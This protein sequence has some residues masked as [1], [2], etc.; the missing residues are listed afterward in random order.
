MQNKEIYNQF[1]ALSTKKD[2]GKDYEVIPINNS[3]H[4]IGCSKEG[5]PK[6]FIATS[7][8]SN[9]T[10]NT[11]LNILFVE[12]NLLCKHIDD[13]NK[14]VSQYYTVITLT[15]I[16]TCLQEDFIDLVVMMLTRLP[17]VPTKKEISIE[18]ENLISIFSSMSC[19]PRKKIQ[20]LWTELLVIEQSKT[21]EVLTKAWHELPNSKYDFTMGGDKIE[22]KS[23]NSE[24]R[25]HHFSLEQLCPSTHSRILIA[26]SIVHESA[27]GDGGMNISDLYDK[28]CDKNISIDARIHIM[29][30]IADTIGSDIHKIDSVYYDYVGACDSLKFYDSNS[31]PGIDKNA[32]DTGVT[33]VGFVSNLTGIEDVLSPDSDFKAENSLLYDSLFKN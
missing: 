9:H 16:E 30:V 8:D 29:K 12:Y 27:R 22:V 33:S 1:K 4:K 24:N 23:T 10:K 3:L 6:F 28:I 31:I 21:P 20:G 15:S 5:Y 7:G 14:E 11:I 25:T 18:V 2:N 32:I 13:K 26:S 17:D 19:P